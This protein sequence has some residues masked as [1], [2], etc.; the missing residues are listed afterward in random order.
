MSTPPTL[1]APDIESTSD[2]PSF[3]LKIALGVTGLIVVGFVVLHRT[4]GGLPG[5]GP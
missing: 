4:D 1:P 3:E 5:R 2:G